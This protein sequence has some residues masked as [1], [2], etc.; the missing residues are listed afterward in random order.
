MNLARSSLRL[1][2]TCWLAAGPPC[3]GHAGAAPGAAGGKPVDYRFRG[4]ITREV[5]ENY[6]ARSIT[7]MDLCSGRIDPTDDIRM[8]GRIG[9]KFAGRTVYLWGG[10]QHLD[11]KLKHARDTAARLHKQD[12]DMILQAGIFE[13]VTTEVEKVPVPE[14]AL[15]EFGL[16]SEKRTFRYA[17]MLFDGGRFHDHWQKGASVPDITKVETRMWFY[18]LARQ[19]VD[20]GMEAIHW[21]QVALIGA[22]DKDFAAWRDVL[23]RARKHAARAARRRLLICDAHTPDGGPI[24]EGRLLFDFHSFPMR[25]KEVVGKPQEGVLEVGYLDSIFKRSKGGV[26]PSGWKCGS[27]PYLVEFDNW[28]VSPKPGEGGQPWWTWGY[29]EI[30]WFAHQ[31]EDYR[32][33][34]LRYAYEW[35]RTTDRNGYLE[36]PGSRCIHHP[37]GAQWWYR[38]NA[39]SAACPDGYGQEDAIRSVW[40]PAR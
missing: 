12:P 15:A 37:V 23:S 28:G 3:T 39:R 17:G 30:T 13:I 9:A 34:W 6:L 29:D 38:A 1:A 36:M 31:P 11:A 16:P 2:A 40:S 19:Y 10:E 14:W 24:H 35:V 20:A 7:M 21:G 25:I 27:L 22:G 18:F 33:R 4:S 26:A 5:L 32:N 8:L